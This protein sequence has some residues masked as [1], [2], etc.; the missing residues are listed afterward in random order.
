M[1]RRATDRRLRLP[2]QTRHAG[3]HPRRLRR[4]RLP[5]RIRVEHPAQ[6]ER[7][8]SR[9]TGHAGVHPRRRRPYRQTSRL[10]PARCGY[11]RRSRHRRR[12][13]PPQHRR[14]LPRPREHLRHALRSRPGRRGFLRHRPRHAGRFGRPFSRARGARRPG[15]KLRPR[16][17]HQL[18][19]RGEHPEKIPA[20]RSILRPRPAHRRRG[21]PNRGC[22]LWNAIRGLY[23]SLSGGPH[24]R[25]IVQDAERII[26][27]RPRHLLRPRREPEPAGRGDRLRHIDLGRQRLSERRRAA[28][29]RPTGRPCSVPHRLAHVLAKAS[30]RSQRSARPHVELFATAPHGPAKRPSRVPGRPAHV[31]TKTSGRTERSARP[32]AELLVDEVR[33]NRPALDQSGEHVPH[34]LDYSPHEPR[35]LLPLNLARLIERPVPVLAQVRP[36]LLGNVRALEDQ[37]ELV[38]VGA[39]ELTIPL[40]F[41][42]LATPQPLDD[43]AVFQPPPAALGIV[44]VARLALRVD[45]GQH[46]LAGKEHRHVHIKRASHRQVSIRERLRIDSIESHRPEHRRYLAAHLIRQPHAPQRRAVLRVGPLLLHE[47]VEDPDCRIDPRLQGLVPRGRGSRAQPI[48]LKVTPLA[49]VQELVLAIE[50]RLVG[51]EYSPTSGLIGLQPV[52]PRRLVAGRRHLAQPPLGFKLDATACKLVCHAQLLHRVSVLDLTKRQVMRALHGRLRRL[53]LPLLARQLRRHP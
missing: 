27:L 43:H 14:R 5:A 46:A 17:A 44:H 6:I 36:D 26:S 10:H 24:R 9:L 37:L 12:H 4:R 31:R 30:G 49:L 48:A 7:R 20:L 51:V 18:I 33:R 50:R 13:T 3:V 35:S 21:I 19:A 42:S 29:R 53:P 45:L 2:G 15:R 28:P 1:P 47:L 52:Q 25:Q 39:P 16:L 32:H 22:E 41:R 38:L 23:G 8:D 11:R 40:V 34:T